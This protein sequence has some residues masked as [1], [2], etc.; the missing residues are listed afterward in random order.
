MNW[1]VGHGAEHQLSASSPRLTFQNP[2]QRR[3]SI[4][5]S[6]S[7]EYPNYRNVVYKR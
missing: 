3:R 4:Q 6:I 5:M 1:V 2:A 7:A